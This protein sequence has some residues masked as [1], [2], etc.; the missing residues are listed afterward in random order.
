MSLTVTIIM[1]VVS[2]L[3][4]LGLTRWM[5]GVARVDS[6]WLRYYLHVPLAMGGG[7]G[8]SLLADNWAELIGFTLL[9][10]GCALLVC[11]DLAAM[12]LP[13]VMVGPLYLVLLGSLVVATIMAGDPLRLFTA[14][15]C[16]AAMLVLYLVLALIRPGQLG[17][18]DVKF[19]GVIGLF[20]GWLGW[21]EVMLGML[22]AFALSAVVGLGLMWFFK[23]GKKHMLPFGPFMVAGAVVGAVA[24]TDFLMI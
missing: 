14:L 10:V 9:G 6:P 24:G 20:L 18:G 19:G 7:A 15:G 12:R 1:A 13:N 8:A 5:R 4:A 2:G 16:A 22:A 23:M 17:M 11:V 3:V 21:G